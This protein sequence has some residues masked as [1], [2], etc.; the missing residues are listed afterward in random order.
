MIKLIKLLNEKYKKGMTITIP[1]IQSHLVHHVEVGHVT[2]PPKTMGQRVGTMV[3][4]D[5]GA[6]ISIKPQV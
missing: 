3:V 4:K 6:G 5:V 1:S 2:N